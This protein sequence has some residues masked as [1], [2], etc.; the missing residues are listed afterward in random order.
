[1]WIQRYTL[2][3]RR[4]SSWWC[5][6]PHL[7]TV[8]NLLQTRHRYF[9]N[10]WCLESHLCF[11]N[12]CYRWSQLWKLACQLFTWIFIQLRLLIAPKRKWTKITSSTEI[13]LYG[14]IMGWLVSTFRGYICRWKSLRKWF[15]MHEWITNSTNYK[16]VMHWRIEG[17]RIKC[18]EIP[19]LF[20]KLVP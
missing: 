4:K 15:P 2:C 1:M 18:T 19:P 16:T 3:M 10:Q 7:T 12:T 6:L 13:L 17:S 14:I 8:E 5:C 11:G 9:T 20:L